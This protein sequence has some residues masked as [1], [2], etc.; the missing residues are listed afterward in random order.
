M[1][2]RDEKYDELAGIICQM[3]PE[4]RDNPI[5]QI[6]AEV[7]IYFGKPNYPAEK[8]FENLNEITPIILTDVETLI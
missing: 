5:T 2:F 1:K 6:L 7:C 4:Q 3:T 8:L